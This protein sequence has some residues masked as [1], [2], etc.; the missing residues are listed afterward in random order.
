MKYYKKL[1]WGILA[2]GFALLLFVVA[3]FQVD[4]MTLAKGEIYNFNENWELSWLDEEGKPVKKMALEE[5]PYLG[6]SEPGAVVVMSNQI[7]KEYF[8]K[9]MSFLSAD[10]KLSVMVDG[11]VV[12]EFGV[13]DMRSFGRTPGSVVNFVDIPA[14]LT[15]G[16]I[17]IK[18]VSPYKDY[19]ARVTQ[20]TVGE[21]DVL[22]LQL[23]KSNIISIASNFV[24]LVCGFIFFLL[25]LVRKFVKED[26]SGMQYLC[27]YCIVASLYY[28][29]ET[30]AL[31]VF[32][33]NQT[34]YSVMVFLCLMMMPFF[35]GLYYGNGMLGMFEKRWN[36]LLLLTTI[37]AV[38]Q[39]G[40]QLF[41]I[42]DFMDMAFI[43][44]VLIMLTVILVGKSY[45]DIIKI[46]KGKK[47]ITIQLGV[48]ALL[49]MGAGGTIDIV[50][51]YVVAVGDMGKYSRLGT[52]AFS[53]IML[54]QHLSQILIG[55]SKNI[56]EN[57]RLLQQE[58]EFVAMKNEQLEKAKEMAEEARQEALAANAAKGKF[59]AHMSHEIRTPINAVLGMDTMILRETTDMQIKEY[60]LDIQNAGQNLLSLINDIL[61][62][63]K[64]ESGKLEI[65]NV[66][67]DFSSMIHDISNMIKAKAEGKKLELH[68]QIDENLPSKLF[69]DDVR[70]RQV[71][72]NLLNNAVKYTLEGRVSLS[73]NGRIDG[74]KV[75]LDFSVEDTG[76]GIKEEDM[77]KLF[78]EFERIE[79]KRNRNV[80]GTGLGINITTQLLMLMG[81]K[82]NVES[83]YGKGSKFYFTLE[84]NIVDST[85]VGNL[86]ERIRQQSTEYS[87]MAAFTA[88]KAE[89]LVV[90]DNS[91]NLKVFVN[92]LK[93]TKVNVDVADSGK[94]CLEMVRKKRYDLIFLDHMMPEMDGIETL[95]RM[96]ELPDNQSAGTPIVA[97]TANA[98]TGAKEMYLAEGFDAF[99][100]K[101]INPEKLEQMILRLLPRDLLKFEVLSEDGG[102]EDGEI[103]LQSQQSSSGIGKRIANSTVDV[104][105]IPM[106]DGIDWSYGL[107][108]LPDKELL[109]DTVKDFHKAI[110]VEADA[111]EKFY[112]ES[113]EPSNNLDHYRIK[114]HS[115][116][117]SANLIGA[118]VLGGMAKL[119][120]NAARDGNIEVI[121]SLHDIFIKEWRSYKQS[122]KECLGM[123]NVLEEALEQNKKEI[124]DY[125]ILLAYLEI[126][127]NA[128]EEMDIDEMDQMIVNLEEYAYPA[129]IQSNIEKLSV[130]VTNMAVEEAEP[131]IEEIMEQLK[132]NGE[133]SK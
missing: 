10:K 42:V 57:A 131:L 84:Q 79:E 74:K 15:E 31:H 49:F 47:D 115:M 35:M 82:L 105:D 95:H 127:R 114:V 101:P 43:S 75:V 124:E 21:R 24:I 38:G 69:G 129:D 41:N 117:S 37:N 100:P 76:I 40:L 71:L 23:L 56:E 51:M 62:F 77:E 6:E 118:T 72:V 66:E 67:Y 20:I 36:G 80:E 120:E 14:N 11:A 107:M 12:Y 46:N 64:I 112:A 102:I 9:T 48:A 91:T 29:I 83:T 111:L 54:Y 93:C 58:M 113:K 27:A 17:E 32:Y 132:L 133:G 4:D 97:L 96:K 2:F 78:K 92:L 90:D 85:P 18:M 122:L 108:H 34:L 89:L 121:E 55:Y 8:G 44:H 103:V 45:L 30:K 123:D 128:F 125:T 63:S 22:I 106:V 26:T 86:T 116:K 98:I 60:A 59:L 119:L 3:K 52:M 1:A 39:I 13:N 16:K 19:A 50:R 68:F 130:L 7:P 109:M 99:L 81:S 25:Y 70:I 28:F 88:P 110:D 53:I 126:L 104:S 33:G 65:I 87:Y 5:L 73:V 61:D 94:S